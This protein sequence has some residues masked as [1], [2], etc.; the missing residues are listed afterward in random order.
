MHDRSLIMLSFACFQSATRSSAELLFCCAIHHGCTGNA[1]SY[2][3]DVL[4]AFL[5]E[6]LL[7]TVKETN[8]TSRDS[9][10]EGHKVRRSHVEMRPEVGGRETAVLCPKSQGHEARSEGQKVIMSEGHK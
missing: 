9:R 2:Q 8:T 1:N 10:S 3:V 4:T 6:P 5:L 7:S